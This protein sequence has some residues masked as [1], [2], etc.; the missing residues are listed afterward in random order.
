MITIGVQQPNYFPWIGY[1]AKIARSDVFVLLDDVDYQSGNASSV[2]NRTRIKT[3]TGSQLLSVPVRHPAGLVREATIDERHRW[4]RKHVE[5]LRFAYA[6]S[7]FHLEVLE[8]AKGVIES[9]EGKLAALNESGIR[10]MCDYLGIRTTLV[11]SSELALR[12]TERN[13]RLVEICERLNATVYLSGAG[14]RRYN[15]MSLFAARGVTV[16]YLDF[17]C[18]AYPQLHG[19]F[20]GNLSMLD[21]L[22]NCGEGA[23]RLLR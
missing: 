5:T 7:K 6:K 16:R 2:T 21:A 13:E 1:L 8:L 19:T 17:V 4:P 20:V 12:S 22:F 10:A 11:R 9:G 3:S 18:P 14:G 15:D 23:M